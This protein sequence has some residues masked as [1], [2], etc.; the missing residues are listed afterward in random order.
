MMDEKKT[1]APSTDTG[2][3]G[4]TKKE[5]D[6]GHVI[7]W[8]LIIGITVF[9]VG[10]IYT[11]GDLIMPTGKTSLFLL[12]PL[13]LKIIII[14]AFMFGFFMLFVMYT[15]MYR[16]GTDALTKAIFSAEKMYRQ[17]KTSS[18][19]RLVTAGL[20]ISIFVI[21]AGIIVGLFQSSGNTGFLSFLASISI[22]ETILTIASLYLLFVTLAI[23]FMWLWSQGT[24]FFQK[25]FFS[26]EM[27]G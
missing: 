15:V 10:F 1:E 23:L 27:E 25:R 16:K 21:A 13:G 24:I 17:M 14:G 6:I 4:F 8:M 2:L 20:M 11:I 12:F 26:K 7:F 9:F 3:E 5:H 22:G 18:G 19:A